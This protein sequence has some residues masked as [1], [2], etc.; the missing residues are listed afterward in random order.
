MNEYVNSSQS[1]SLMLGRRHQINIFTRLIRYTEMK[2]VG[3]TDRKKNHATLDV[4]AQIKSIIL[5]VIILKRNASSPI[6]FRLVIKS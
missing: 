4:R 3:Y 2:T 5:K 1:G 6:F